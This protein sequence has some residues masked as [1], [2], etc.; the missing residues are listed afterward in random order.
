MT[1]RP[2]ALHIGRTPSSPEPWTRGFLG[3][4]VAIWLSVGLQSVPHIQ[5]PRPEKL[6]PVGSWVMDRSVAP[7][8]VR[9][10]PGLTGRGE[11]PL[12]AAPGLLFGR[13]LDVNTACGRDLTVI[14]GIGP[15]RA[16]AI[17]EARDSDPYRS[18][19][20]LTRARGV[21]PGT[22]SRIANWVT[23]EGS[24]ASGPSQ[25]AASAVPKVTKRARSYGW[26]SGDTLRGACNGQWGQ[27]DGQGNP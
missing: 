15:S 8:R 3:L 26:V 16:Q 9:C 25:P 4:S 1:E 24:G 14:P 12:G 20:D 2:P 22:L 5:T 27:A 21:G 17:L 11:E 7:A 19:S 23:V 10:A 18:L 6:C 13:P